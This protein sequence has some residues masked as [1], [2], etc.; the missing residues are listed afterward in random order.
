LGRE[1]GGE[2]KRRREMEKGKV[3]RVYCWVGKEEGKGNG[4]GKGRRGRKAEYIVG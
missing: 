3:G 1:G 2:G 4:E